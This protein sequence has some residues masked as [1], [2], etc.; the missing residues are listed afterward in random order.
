MWEHQDVTPVGRIGSYLKNFRVPKDCHCLSVD[1]HAESGSTIPKHRL[2]YATISD[3]VNLKQRM[4]LLAALFQR[5]SA[6]SNR[7]LGWRCWSKPNCRKASFSSGHV[8]KSTPWRS[9]FWL[10]LWNKTTERY[11]HTQI[12]LWGYSGKEDLSASRKKGRLSQQVLP[13]PGELPS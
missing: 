9:S 10:K 5:S 1:Q 3:S 8:L 7:C 4:D 11:C 2:I 12:Y 6:L 13:G